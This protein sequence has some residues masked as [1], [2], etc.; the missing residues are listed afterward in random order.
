MTTASQLHC[1]TV[2]LLHISPN[3]PIC[4]KMPHF[5]C[6]SPQP[7]RIRAQTRLSPSNH[8][9]NCPKGAPKCPIPTDILP[10]NAP[11]VPKHFLTR[12]NSKR[13]ASWRNSKGSH[14]DSANPKGPH[15]KSPHLRP[16]VFIRGSNRLPLCLCASVFTLV[17]LPRRRGQVS[18]SQT[19]R[20]PQ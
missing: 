10:Q 19:T 1:F 12:R 20:P 11:L 2:S 3:A 9:P 4:P 17:V 5:F 8:A 6:A 18:L 16:S 7:S 15:S 14:L 13:V